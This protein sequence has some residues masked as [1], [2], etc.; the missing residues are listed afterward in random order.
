MVKLISRYNALQNYLNNDNYLD[1][2]DTYFQVFDYSKYLCILTC[3]Q[4]LCSVQ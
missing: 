1:N 4:I 2:N 3:E